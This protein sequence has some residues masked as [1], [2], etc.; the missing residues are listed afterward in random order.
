MN[1]TFHV[2][3]LT[4]DPELKQTQNGTTLCTFT[5]AVNRR[6]KQDGTREADYIPVVA[7]RGQADSCYRYL[8]KGSKVAV[9]GEIR[10]STYEHNGEKRPTWNVEATEVEFLSARKQ[11]DME[12]VDLP[13]E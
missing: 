3:N 8:K 1:K 12:E 6:P 2:G 7:W 13:W 9:A 10:T 5:I 11:N 4:R